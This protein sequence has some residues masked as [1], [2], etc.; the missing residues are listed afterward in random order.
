MLSGNVAPFSGKITICLQYLVLVL[1]LAVNSE[2]KSLIGNRNINNNTVLYRGIIVIYVSKASKLGINS[3]IMS[4][5]DR[6]L[7]FISLWT[8]CFEIS[9]KIVIKVLN[10]IINNLYKFPSK[11]FSFSLFH[12]NVYIEL[13]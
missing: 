5:Y 9:L 2:Y 1:M 4:N 11:L 13:N 6:W 10:L 12:I 7:S 8:L 3:S